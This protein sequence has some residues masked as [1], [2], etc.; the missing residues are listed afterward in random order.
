VIKRGLDTAAASVGLLLLWPLFILVALLIKTDSKG[1]VFFKQERIGRDFRPFLIYK[2][3]TMAEDAADRGALITA[4][5]DPRVTRIGRW[6]RKSK[7]DELPQLI[8][9]LK[10]DMAFVGPRPEV[11]KYVELF[12][13]D[14]EQILKVRPGITDP[15]SLKFHDEAKVLGN[16]PEPEKEYVGRILPEKLAL[17]KTYVR[18]GSLYSDLALIFATLRRVVSR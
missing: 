10:G 6:L 16:F 8:N 17:A 18:E 1:P 7:V 12:R 13:S 9:V 3:R 15:A 5:E 4:G 2:F 11:R 14:Y